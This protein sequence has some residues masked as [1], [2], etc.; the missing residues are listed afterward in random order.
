MVFTIGL[1]CEVFS[2]A[3]MAERL[4]EKMVASVFKLRVA[5]CSAS[6]IANSSAWK[7]ELLVRLG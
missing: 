4:S 5:H 3:L 2:I 6:A 1:I 7:T